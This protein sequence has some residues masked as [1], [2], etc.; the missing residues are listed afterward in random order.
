MEISC[1][2]YT[3]YQVLVFKGFSKSELGK[4]CKF[5]SIK[6]MLL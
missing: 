1:N 2:G 5:I 3:V 4:V 6:M